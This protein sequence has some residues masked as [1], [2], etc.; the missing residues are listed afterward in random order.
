VKAD[1]KAQEMLASFI[2]Q[3]HV[4]FYG[5]PPAFNSNDKQGHVV[6]YGH[7]AFNSNYIA[8]NETWKAH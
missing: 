4:V 7:Q 2:K 3:G 6:F 1:W 5:P 8:E